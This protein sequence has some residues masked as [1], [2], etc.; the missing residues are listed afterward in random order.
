MERV[1]GGR[2]HFC[3]ANFGCESKHS[4]LWPRHLADGAR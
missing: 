3:A 2:T 1:L 4:A